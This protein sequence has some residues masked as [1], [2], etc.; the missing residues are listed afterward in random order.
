[1]LALWQSEFVKAELERAYGGLV[2]ELRHIVTTGDRTQDSSA[3]IPEIGGKGLFTA[4]LEDALAANEVDLAV[5]SLKDLPTTLPQGFCVAAI[6]ERTGSEDVLISRDGCRL[7][8]LPRG[9]VVGTSSVRRSSQLKIYR[10]DLQAEHIRGNVDTRIR[11]L[12]GPDSPYAAIVLARAGVERLRLMHNVTEIIP[13]DVMLPAP[14]QGAL[15]I[16]CREDDTELHSMLQVLHHPQT[17][18]SVT[19]ERAFLKRLEAGCNT[20]V[21]AL[22]TVRTNTDGLLTLVFRG[23]CAAP[24]GSRHI[25]VEG[26]APIGSATE[27]GIRMAEDALARGFESLQE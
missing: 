24:D 12:K 9:A 1:M 5:H 10:A 26:E 18:A 27:L 17:A 8:D 23:R 3:P 20:P 25:E 16:E 2:V 7:A 4:E 19:A 21:A 14:G 11:K 22:A 15:G 13:A 6:P